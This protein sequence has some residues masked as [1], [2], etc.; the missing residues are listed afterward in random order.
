MKQDQLEE[1]VGGQPLGGIRPSVL[2]GDVEQGLPQG[3]PPLFREDETPSQKALKSFCYLLCCPF[4]SAWLTLQRVQKALESCLPKVAGCLAA[5]F[6]GILS[7][8]AAVL[9]AIFQAVAAVLSA[10]Y[11]RVLKPLY[12]NVLKP[13]GQALVKGATL[14]C[15][16][17]GY[18]GSTVF[19]AIASALQAIRD[20]VLAGERPPVGLTVN[21]K[22]ASLMKSCWASDPSA[23]PTMAKVT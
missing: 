18:V 6:D 2:P 3:R 21:G 7:A 4:V 5:V 17:I 9:E 23:R 8:F 10:F 12:D 1:Q 20:K 22:I 16:A 11:N 13:L 19:G 14:V 15:G